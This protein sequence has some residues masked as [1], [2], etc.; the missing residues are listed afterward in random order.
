MLSHGHIDHAGACISHARAKALN[1][2]PATYIVPEN[3]LL[4]LLD[5]KKAFETM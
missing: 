2:S 1:S 3:L 5:A 4:P